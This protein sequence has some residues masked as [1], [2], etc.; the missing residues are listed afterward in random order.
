MLKMRGSCSTSE[1]AEAMGITQMAIRRHIQSLEKDGIIQS[2][3]VRQAMGRPSYRYSLTE[4]ADNLFPKNYS[5]L[6]LDLLGQLAN[7][8]GGD[9]IIVRIFE[10]RR[11]R[12]E[13]R[14]QSRMNN[15]SPEQ[16]ISVLTEI[17]NESGYMA[18][19]FPDEETPGA[20]TLYEYNCPVAQVAKQ[21]R[22]ACHCEREL[23][24]KLLD[25]EVERTECLAEGHIRCTYKIRYRS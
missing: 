15:L 10:G 19:C 16:K 6:A 21:Y 8:E 20:Y 17:Q 14:Y 22:Q 11:D 9:D 13:S 18:E 3:L 25:A 2:T 1:M 24:E 23:F 5:Q 4:T 7:Q 12:L